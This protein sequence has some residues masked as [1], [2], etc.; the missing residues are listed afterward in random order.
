MAHLRPHSP[1]TV[2]SSADLTVGFPNL[3]G[4]DFATELDYIVKC[5][6]CLTGECR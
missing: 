3:I 2:H 5:P 4:Q 6:Q 1:F